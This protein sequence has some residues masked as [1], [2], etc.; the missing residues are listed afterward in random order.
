[1]PPRRVYWD[2]C[3]FI[4]YLNGDVDRVPVLEALLEQAER[5]ELLIVTS[6]VSLTE[7]AFTAAERSGSELSEADEDAIDALLG[8]R[9]TV[10]LVEFSERIA[11]EARALMRN[12][13]ARGWSLKPMDAIHLASAL[14]A[15]AR[16]FHT[17]DDLSRFED[18]VEYSI[19]EPSGA[20]PGLG[21]EYTEK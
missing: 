19:G 18:L 5:E 13:V 10:V 20:R 21:L 1:M 3:C 17:Y 16:E 11:R 2:A 7:V 12:A 9:A 14:F 8:N 15:D 4:S 6:M